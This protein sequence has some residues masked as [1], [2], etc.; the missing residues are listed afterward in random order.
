[1]CLFGGDSRHVRY[2]SRTALHFVE[3]SLPVKS[4]GVT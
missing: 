1:V 2:Q 4:L 3:G